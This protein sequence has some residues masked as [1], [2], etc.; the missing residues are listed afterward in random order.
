MG[1]SFRVWIDYN[2]NNNQKGEGFLS[3]VLRPR[4]QQQHRLKSGGPLLN[5]SV[6]G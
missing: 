1:I 5:V 4:Q 2:N 3:P 6:H